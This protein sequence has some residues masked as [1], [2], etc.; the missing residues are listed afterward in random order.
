MTREHCA[1]Y[2]F[3]TRMAV[4]VRVK[5]GFSCPR[6]AFR[7]MAK[8]IHSLHPPREIFAATIAFEAP[9]EA[10]ARAFMEGDPAIAESFATGELREVRVSLLRDRDEERMRA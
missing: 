1:R 2:R 7:S 3:L 5:D 6:V 4:H 8:W 10:S 9:D